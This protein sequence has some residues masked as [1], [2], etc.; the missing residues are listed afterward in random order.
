MSETS[1]VP[2]HCVIGFLPVGQAHERLHYLDAL[3]RLCER[4]DC[5]LIG[6][7]TA[8]WVQLGL[9]ELAAG[10]EKGGVEEG[11]STANVGG[12]MELGVE[13][14]DEGIE[15]DEDHVHDVFCG[16]LVH[17]PAFD[18]VVGGVEGVWGV[19]GRGGGAWQIRGAIETGGGGGGI[20]VLGT[21][22][23][24]GGSEDGSKERVALLLLLDET[25]GVDALLVELALAL[26][27]VHG[28]GAGQLGVVDGVGRGVERGGTEA[29]ELGAVGLLVEVDLGVGDTVGADV[30]AGLCACGLGLE[31]GV[32][33]AL[34]ET[35]EHLGGLGEP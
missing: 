8:L 2:T 20:G 32:V 12:G 4:S 10:H 5:M 25:G 14:V 22:G 1:A 9:E 23:G 21:A 19:C 6:E 34:L 18:G 17:E 31:F 3:L 33:E 28:A 13:E 27:F 35:T 15:A 11:T 26:V 24:A 29:G 30:C 7:L 16:R